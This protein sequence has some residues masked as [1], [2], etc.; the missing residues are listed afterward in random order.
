VLGFWVLD[1]ELGKRVFL[2]KFG[3]GLRK[4]EGRG[5][6]GR[7]KNLIYLASSVIEW[8]LYYTGAPSKQVVFLNR[9]F[10]LVYF[11]LFLFFIGWVLVFIC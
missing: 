9:D 7:G 10:V 5:F 6:K 3:K 2:T 1:W 4:C 11:I 8:S